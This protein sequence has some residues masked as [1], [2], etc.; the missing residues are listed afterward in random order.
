M[1]PRCSDVIQAIVNGTIIDATGRPPITRG[2]ILIA[3]DRIAAIGDSTVCVPA[4]AMPIDASG[5]FVIPGLMDANVHL[6]C[7]FW[8]LTLVR[9]EDRY[10]ELALEAAQIALRA[11]VTTVFDTWGPRSALRRARD[12][13]AA[14]EVPGA[15]V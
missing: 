6:I 10:H 5:Q 13:I 15:R 12:Q 3:D 11:G 7:D 14:G 8:P 9:Y 4:D 2:V 1:S